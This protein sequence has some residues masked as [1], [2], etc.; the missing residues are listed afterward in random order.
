MLS[1]PRSKPTPVALAIPYNAVS[2]VWGD[3]I[4]S[5]ELSIIAVENSTLPI[6]PI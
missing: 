5:T 4:P 6:T 1:S 2:Y 3:G